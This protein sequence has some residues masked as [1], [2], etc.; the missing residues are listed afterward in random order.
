MKKTTQLFSIFLLT[1]IIGFQSCDK[2]D[3]PVIPVPDIDTNV[4][5]GNFFDYEFPTFGEN[6]NTHRNALIEDYTGHQCPFCPPAAAAAEEIRD[7]KPEGRVFL[8]AVHATPS[9]D[10]RGPFQ[11]TTSF[12][13]RDFK[14]PQGLEMASTFKQLDVGFASNPSG[15]INRI[16]DETGNFFFDYG[17]WEGFVDV[18]LASPLDVNIQAKSNYFEETRG[19]YLHTETEF[20]NNLSGNYNIVVYAIEDSYVGPQKMPDGSKDTFY[21]HH[22]IHLGNLFD[23]TWGRSVANG[24][25]EAGSKFRTDFSYT[26]PEGLNKD[27]MHFIISVFNRDTYEIMQVIKHEIE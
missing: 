14:N 27:E 23:E 25:I 13:N 5:P 19:L 6:L 7:L 15:N 4:Y 9:N 18:V 8:V 10:G 26:L 20:K 21:V 3:F 2:V 24:E 16:Q 17:D 22:D 1:L 12:F 11:A